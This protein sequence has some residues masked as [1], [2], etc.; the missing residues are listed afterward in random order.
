MHLRTKILLGGQNCNSPISRY[1]VFNYFMCVSLCLYVIICPLV[2]FS[3]GLV[4]NGYFG[5]F[6]EQG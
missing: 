5:L 4:L 6:G 3:L 2:Y 1:F